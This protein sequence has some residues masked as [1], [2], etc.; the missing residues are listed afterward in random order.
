M[1]SCGKKKRHTLKSQL[2]IDTQSLKV[3]CTAHGTGKEHDF[4]LFKRSQ[5]KPLSI[6]EVLADKGYQGIKNI[7]SLS[8]T[9]FKKTKKKP[10]SLREK[11]Y[12]R[13]LSKNR[14]YI[15]H[16]IRCLKIFRILAQP[17]RNRRRRFGLRFN[18]IAGLYNFGLDLAIA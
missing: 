8:Y 5:V 10:L 13:E 9:P 14:I 16:V 12:N 1:R 2:V 17:Y 6:V 3:I 11:E 18:L 7:H 15:E 4:Q